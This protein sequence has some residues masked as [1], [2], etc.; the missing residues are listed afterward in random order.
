M[1]FKE[2]IIYS[3]KDEAFEDVWSLYQQSFPLEERRS[4]EEQ[5]RIFRSENYTLKVYTGRSFL[6]GFM[7]YWEFDDFVFIEHFALNSEVRSRGYGRKILGDFLASACK[8]V[9]LEIEPV[10]DEITGRRLNF[11]ESLSFKENAFDH[12][13][14]PFH[15]GLEELPLMIMSYPEKISES[16]YNDL[17]YQLKNTIMPGFN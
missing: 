2:R 14:L 17:L 9:I 4:S 6:P 10:A 15:K 11:Y 1:K 13:Q 8:T 5:Q 3:E 12:R 16:M 7:S